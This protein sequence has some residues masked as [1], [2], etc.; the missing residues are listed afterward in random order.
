MTCLPPKEL[1]HNTTFFFFNYVVLVHVRFFIMILGS[2]ELFFV[3]F[4][5]SPQMWRSSCASSHAPSQTQT[6]S[7]LAESSLTT[8]WRLI[9]MPIRDGASPLS[10]HS[11]PSTCTLHQRFST[12]PWRYVLCIASLYTFLLKYEAGM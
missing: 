9:G 11:T 8:C 5:Y 3:L 10:A 2:C 1:G 7:S 4:W 12:M 6:T